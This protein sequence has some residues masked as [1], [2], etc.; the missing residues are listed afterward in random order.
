LCISCIAEQL[1]S[2]CAALAADAQIDQTVIVKIA[3]SDPFCK[4]FVPEQAISLMIGGKPA[5][6]WLR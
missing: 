4:F 3:V 5:S 2:F 6:S 1:Q